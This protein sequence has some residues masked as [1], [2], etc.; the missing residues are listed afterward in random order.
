MS[1]KKEKNNFKKKVTNNKI[2]INCIKIEFYCT[3]NDKDN[4]SLSVIIKMSNLK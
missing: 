1:S 4:C 3:M 2:R